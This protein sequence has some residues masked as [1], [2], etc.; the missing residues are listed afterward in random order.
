MSDRPLDAERKIVKKAAGAAALLE[1]ALKRLSQTAADLDERA[2]EAVIAAADARKALPPLTALSRTLEALDRTVVG[3]ESEARAAADRSRAR[4]AGGLAEALEAAGHPVSGRLPAL[5]C[6][7]L[8]LELV[9]GSRPEVVIWFGPKV[10]EMGR[11]PMVVDKVVSA[12]LD[13]IGHLEGAPLDDAQFLAELHAAWRV[14]L[15]RLRLGPQDRAPINAVLSEI[16]VGRQSDRW[17]LDPSSK[18][19]RP[20]TRVQFAHDLGRLRLRQNGGVELMLTVATRDQTKR[21]TDHLWVDGTHYAYLAF[22][23]A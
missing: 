17:K 23:E 6:G 19:F 16:A 21:A 4:L 12:V 11:A 18:G 8:T 20:Y 10:E 7:P 3:L 9:S 2:F 15:A 13:A 14:A 5:K 22:R 1:Q